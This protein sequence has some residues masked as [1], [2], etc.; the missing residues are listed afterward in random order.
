MP[1]RRFLSWGRSR[2]ITNLV[3]HQVAKHKIG[4]TLEQKLVDKLTKPNITEK[5]YPI[6]P[7][8]TNERD[9][10][11]KYSPEVVNKVVKSDIEVPHVNRFMQGNDTFPPKE[12][13]AQ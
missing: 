3:E 8:L 11:V 12:V 9:N 6:D 2:G 13:F 1:E 7:D 10:V 5:D 4:T